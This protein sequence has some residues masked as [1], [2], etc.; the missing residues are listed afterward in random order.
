[1]STSNNH[2]IIRD[3]NF[4]P[5]LIYNN[6][7]GVTIK[8]KEL[9]V[10][11]GTDATYVRST[12]PYRNHNSSVKKKNCS[13]SQISKRKIHDPFNNVKKELVVLNGNWKTSIQNP[14][15]ISKMHNVNI[16]ELQAIQNTWDNKLMKSS[17]KLDTGSSITPS[18]R[19][20]DSGVESDCTDG[21]LSWLLNYRIHE[22]PPVPDCAISDQH[23][24]Q[25]N[26][27]QD[28]SSNGKLNHVYI[29]ETIPNQYFEHQKINVSRIIPEKQNLSTKEDTLKPHGN[30]CRYSGPKKPPFTYTELIEHALNEKGELTVSGIYQWISDRF[31]FYKQNDDRW[32][33]SVRHNLSINPHFR[34]GSKAV[35]GAGHL[36]TIAQRDDKKNW[37]MKKQ[38]IQQ[39]IQASYNE[40]NRDQQLE[41]ELETATA[42][43]LPDNGDDYHRNGLS[44]INHEEFDKEQ[45]IEIEYVNV[46]DVTTN[47]LEDFLCPPVTKEQMVEECGL[48][49]DYLITDLNPNTLG[50]N[51]PDAEIITSG[52]L[53]DD[54]NFQCYEL[55]SDQ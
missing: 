48:N 18:P 21:N 12:I 46:I 39:F 40:Y 44:T 8:W 15:T 35:H 26:N 30:S 14:N 11:T 52:N 54:L 41:I 24:A 25:I 4:Q 28:R 22:L 10:E 16:E 45:N 53:Y 43:I 19:S 17:Q 55:H 3:R 51:L 9:D 50:L 31:P 49:G 27:K 37:N 2:L 20:S 5:G 32:K 13:L 1:M 38:R 6:K 29:A 36:W 7:N 42:S 34:K 33:N 23:D 47:G